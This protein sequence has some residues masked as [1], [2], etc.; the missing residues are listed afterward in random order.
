MRAALIRETGPPENIRIEDVSEPQPSGSEVAVRVACAAVNPIDTYIRS[1]AIAMELPLPYIVGSDLA[2]V[3]EAVG[4]D[5]VELRPGMRVWGSNQ[6]LMGRQGTFAEVIAVDQ[7]WLYPIPDGVS[8]EQA[9][10]SALVG[11]TARLGLVDEANL[12]AGETLLV[13]G[14]SGA[15]G[16]TVIQIARAMGARVLAT[17]SSDAK[18]AACRDFGADAA[19][20]YRR[21]DVAQRLQELAPDGVDVWW[22]TSRLPDFDVALAALKRQGRMVLMAGRDARPEF[23]VGLF[24]ANCLKLYGFVMFLA[25]AEAQAQAAA[26]V[27]RWLQEGKLTTRVDRVESLDDAAQLHQLQESNTLGQDGSVAGKL[28]VKI[29][30]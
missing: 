16:S 5:V 29:A 28:V 19:I 1:G 9:A 7:R 6:G 17:T 8:D 14:G 13:S 10:A 30:S 25:T 22:E 20:D 26:D 2:G 3:V 15:V 4:P 24:Y 11:I 18:A 12:Q 23:P 27:N 21:E